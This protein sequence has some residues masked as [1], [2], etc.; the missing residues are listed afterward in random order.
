MR[1]L[2]L[3]TVLV[4][5]LAVPAVGLALGGGSDD[6]TLS[7][8]KGIGKVTLNFNGSVVGRIARGTVRANDPISSDGAG[9]DV[10]GCEKRND[11]EDDTTTVCSGSG[12][13]FR[14]IG[15]KY[16]LAI[17]G[18]GI[19][20]SAV[21]HGSGSLNGRGEDASDYDGVYSLND[22]PYK[23]LPNDPQTFPLAAP[24]GD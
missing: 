11:N 20:L 4:I 19:F 5:G 2:V 18:S 23:S 22:S 12:I 8:K 14:A 16:Q 1:R 6:G 10:W 24:S 21:G 13:R 7:V 3:F 17:R 9:V 15:G